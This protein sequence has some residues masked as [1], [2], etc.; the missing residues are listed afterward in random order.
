VRS[1]GRVRGSLVS[2]LLAL[3]VIKLAWIVVASLVLP[4]LFALGFVVLLGML[5]K[6]F[7][8]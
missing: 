8:S 4:V 6:Y 7:L 2:L 1:I 3:V 5:Y